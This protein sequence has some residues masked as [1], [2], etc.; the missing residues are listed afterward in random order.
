MRIYL[1]IYKFHED[2]LLVNTAYTTYSNIFFLIIVCYN[3]TWKP[4]VYLNSGEANINQSQ[5][6]A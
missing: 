2:V 5:W 6:N 3:I 1:E 4:V